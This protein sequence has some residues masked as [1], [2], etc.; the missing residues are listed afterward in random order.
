MKIYDENAIFYDSVNP[1]HDPICRHRFPLYYNSSLNQENCQDV[2]N[3][4]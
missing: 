1:E 3:A 4:I 2:F